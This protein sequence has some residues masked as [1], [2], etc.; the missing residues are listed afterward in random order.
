MSPPLFSPHASAASSPPPC[1]R[2]PPSSYLL[3]PPLSP[4]PAAAQTLAPVSLDPNSNRIHS[5]LL[6]A[7]APFLPSAP[8]SFPD[9][10][11]SADLQTK[12]QAVVRPPD[13]RRVGG[14]QWRV[15]QIESDP[16]GGEGTGRRVQ[17]AEAWGIGEMAANRVSSTDLDMAMAAH[18]RGGGER[19]SGAT[20]IDRLLRIE[21]I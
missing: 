19:P 11:H 1:R 6:T 17:A 15:D 5:H 3:L 14:Q 20:H 7:A 4:V 9:P 12:G 8:S 21:M 13:P 16:D 18:A 10:H 2:A